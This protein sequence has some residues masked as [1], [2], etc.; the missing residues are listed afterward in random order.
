M[1]K[2]A[3]LTGS[4]SVHRVLQCTQSAVQYI[5]IEICVGVVLCITWRGNFCPVSA[6]ID[7]MESVYTQGGRVVNRMGCAVTDTSSI[8]KYCWQGFVYSRI[9]SAKSLLFCITFSAS[10]TNVTVALLQSHYLQLPRKQTNTGTSITLTA[11]THAPTCTRF[12]HL[13]DL[14]REPRLPNVTCARS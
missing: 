6:E 12:P 3:C 5:K 13:P 7:I 14:W 1:K 8:V 2:Y 10:L 9:T 4:R 11:E